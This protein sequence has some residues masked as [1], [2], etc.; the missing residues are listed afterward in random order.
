M[1]IDGG[2][3]QAWGQLGAQRSINNFRFR[4]SSGPS[5]INRG[6]GVISSSVDKRTTTK[7]KSNK[8]TVMEC[9]PM[10]G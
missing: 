5:W 7:I 10:Q 6:V 9:K 3:S 2:G 8:S 1:V 4:I